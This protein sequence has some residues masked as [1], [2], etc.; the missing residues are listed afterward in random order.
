MSGC[1]LSRKCRRFQ[2]HFKQIIL[3]RQEKVK[4]E[5][6]FWNRMKSPLSIT[7][8]KPNVDLIDLIR[9][10]ERN[11]YFFMFFQVP[12]HLQATEV[13]Q[14]HLH[15]QEVHRAVLVPCL[16]LR[17][18]PAL[19]LRPNHW[20]E[21]SGH[22]AVW[23]QIEGLHQRVAAQSLLLIHDHVHTG[24]PGHPY[25]LL[26][27]QVCKQCCLHRLGAAVLASANV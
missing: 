22:P 18:S 2:W 13:P 11:C 6:F 14:H 24:D 9:I 3:P 4:G 20:R 19:H 26:L 16:R 17:R 21:G 15:S 27:F 5:A 12:G 1:K 23:M 25:H 7:F 10:H 8:F